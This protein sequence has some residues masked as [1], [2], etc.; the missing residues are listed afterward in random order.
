MQSNQA[1][2]LTPPRPAPPL[3]PGPFHLPRR[4]TP[5]CSGTKAVQTCELEGEKINSAELILLVCE[6]LALAPEWGESCRAGGGG[7]VAGNGP[8]DS[9]AGR[10]QGQGGAAG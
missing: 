6:L 8:G 1:P 10:E 5:H 2:V 4:D 3:A 9:L 7:G